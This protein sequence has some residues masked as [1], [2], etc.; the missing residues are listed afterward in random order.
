[1]SHPNSRL[2]P[3]SNFA[4]VIDNVVFSSAVK[5]SPGLGLTESKSSKSPRRGDKQSPLGDL[6]VSP[7]VMV[8][9]RGVEVG[10][11]YEYILSIVVLAL[12]RL[13]KD[14]ETK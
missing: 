10:Q 7:S 13:K 5:N 11:D 14:S 6:A 8:S 1:M 3:G 9:L 2:T 12:E 4:T